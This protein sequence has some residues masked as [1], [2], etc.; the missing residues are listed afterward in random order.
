MKYIL[1]VILTVTACLV[2]TSVNIEDI[3]VLTTE[4]P[5][6]TLRQIQIGGPDTTQQELEQLVLHQP[7]L[8]SGLLLHLPQYKLYSCR[9]MD[10]SEFKYGLPTKWRLEP[11][12][13]ADCEDG[14]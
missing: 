11:P 8:P 2:I 9:P 3:F 6:P 7:E 4:A 14:W 12:N 10:L 5:Q 1:F 13:V